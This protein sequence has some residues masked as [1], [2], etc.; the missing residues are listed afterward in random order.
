MTE[1]KKTQVSNMYSDLIKAQSQIEAVEKDSS[2]PFYKSGYA[3]LTATINA[4]KKILNDN[5]F[6]VLQPIE[7][8]LEGVY[9]CTTLLHQ[10]GGEIKSRMRI[11]PKSPND[12]QAQGSA[13][14]YT[15]RYALQSML[16][17]SAEDDDG[18]RAARTN[19][20]Q[21]NQSQPPAYKCEICSTTVRT[22]HKP[23]CPNIPKV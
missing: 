14:T 23:S 7:S 21:Y 18:K 13:V 2:N 10:S 5:H 4:C 15:R 1:E 16:C 19:S 20:P 12:P 22:G 3:S 9:V 6:A 17:M 8:D 11:S